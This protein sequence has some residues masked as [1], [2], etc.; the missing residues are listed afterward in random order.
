MF[1]KSRQQIKLYCC[2][3]ANMVKLQSKTAEKFYV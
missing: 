3:F 1:N 2:C